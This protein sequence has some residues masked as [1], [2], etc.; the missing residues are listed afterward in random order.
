MSITLYE[1][2]TYLLLLLAFNHFR[3]YNDEFLFLPVAFFLTTGVQ[4][5]LAV[6]A[7]KA[8]WVRVAYTRNIFT[9][10][11]DEKAMTALSY[12]FIGTVVLFFAYKYYNSKLKYPPSP[13]DNQ[14]LFTDFIKTRKTFIVFLFVIFSI[15]N[16]I[17]KGML[18]GVLS[19]GQSYFLLFPMALGGLI[20]LFYILYRNLSWQ[21]DGTTKF[22][23]LLLMLY[24]IFIS[25]N[26]SQ[27]FQFLSWMIA[28]GILITQKYNPIQKIKYYIIGG[29][30][31]LFIFSLAGVARK[32]NISSLTFDQMLKKAT[33]RAEKR[34]DQNMLDGFMMVL[35][36][37]P[38]HLN[39]SYGMEH[40]E[41]LLRPIPRKLW[42]GKPVGGYANKLGLNK[43]EK[44]GTVGI[45][46][47]IY[48]TFYGEGGIMGIIILSII[49]GW[50][51]VKLF[52]YTY[53]YN[54]DMHWLLKGIIIAS[55]IPILRGGDLPGIVAFIGMSYWP[56]FLF[57]WQ[58]NK[59]LKTQA[60]QQ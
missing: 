29:V 10:M 43:Y 35:D 36:V 48:G 52:R 60:V 24:S 30:L 51:F 15:I 59:F 22:I 39:Y 40:F 21:E 54:S 17:F 55:F 32:Q 33:E 11:T 28:I 8:D 2:I 14:K 37:Y 46:Q 50:F 42:P 23:Y 38:K 4:R 13:I 34:E 12:F 25:Y 7:G 47:T 44:F 27:R 31:V 16:T 3:K 9:P 6:E 1:I 58:Y 41:I 45:S 5:Y 56:V 49:Y 26:P 20:L 53:R 57:L 19:M 18:G